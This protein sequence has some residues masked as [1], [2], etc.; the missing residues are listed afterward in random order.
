G[1]FIAA[2]QADVERY[3]AVVKRAAGA[4]S[5][6]TNKQLSVMRLLDPF[7]KG[8]GVPTGEH[9]AAVERAIGEMTAERDAA[10]WRL[11]E[12]K[13]LIADAAKR[14]KR[15]DKTLREKRGEQL[16]LLA[17]IVS[18]DLVHLQVTGAEKQVT[19]D[20]IANLLYQ[21]TSCEREAFRVVSMSGEVHPHL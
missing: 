3:D 21:L 13:K 18:D 1:R 2:D 4:S 17:P 10:A 8:D 11:F 19:T 7:I 6:A 9:F 16:S 14:G 20:G 15:S 12:L 5:R